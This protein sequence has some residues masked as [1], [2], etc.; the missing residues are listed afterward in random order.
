M[1]PSPKQS[2]KKDEYLLASFRTLPPHVEG[3]VIITMEFTH[4]GDGPPPHFLG[5]HWDRKDPSPNTLRVLSIVRPPGGG[6]PGGS[7]KA[8]HGYSLDISTPERLLEAATVV[9]MMPEVYSTLKD[10]D[11]K[12]KFFSLQFTLRKGPQAK[13]ALAKY[14]QQGHKDGLVM[15]RARDCANHSIKKY[16][17]L[18]NVVS[19]LEEHRRK[20]HG[21]IQ[22]ETVGK[23][24]FI[25]SPMRTNP[26]PALPPREQGLLAAFRALPRA[27]QEGA[28][29]KLQQAGKHAGEKRKREEAVAAAE[30]AVKKAREEAARCVSPTWE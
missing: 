9:A 7:W 24:D 19:A 29:R 11:V 4:G 8:P 18:W 25:W 12:K 2:L 16:R 17:P 3:D 13:R 14:L 28:L 1:N 27:H 22:R 26:P 30:A 23:Y 15:N 21:T 20:V 5:A 10:D 6:L